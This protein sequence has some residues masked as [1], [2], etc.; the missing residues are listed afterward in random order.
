MFCEFIVL[1]SRAV[2][3]FT[4]D[5]RSMGHAS[6]F[7]TALI[8]SGRNDDNKEHQVLGTFWP[9]HCSPVEHLPGE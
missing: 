2:G 3:N 1:L 9:R 8:E 5:V 7:Y 4:R 6:N